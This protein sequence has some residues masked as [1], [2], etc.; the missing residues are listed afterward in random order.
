[1]DYYYLALT[2]CINT[3]EMEMADKAYETLEEAKKWISIN[4]RNSHYRHH[5]YS[6]ILKIDCNTLEIA[7]LYFRTPSSRSWL[8]LW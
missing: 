1:M 3:G 4:E 2:E 5:P 6:K 8:Q 7:Q